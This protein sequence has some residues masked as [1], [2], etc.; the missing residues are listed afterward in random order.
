MPLGS[1]DRKKIL[2]YCERDLPSEV[3]FSNEFDFIQNEQL[4]RQ[5]VLEFYSA[6]YVYFAGTGSNEIRRR[7]PVAAARR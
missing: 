3:W 5:L 2:G 1:A 7:N 6:G 4:R